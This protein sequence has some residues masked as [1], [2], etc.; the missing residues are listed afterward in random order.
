MC[1]ASGAAS[2]AVH[3]TKIMKQHMMLMLWLGLVLGVVDGA[4]VIRLTSD[5]FETTTQAA[6]GQTTGIWS[7]WGEREFFPDETAPLITTPPS[8]N[9]L[10]HFRGPQCPPCD[11]I[12]TIMARYDPGDFPGVAIRMAE[13]DVDQSKALLTRFAMLQAP[14][15]VLFRSR[16][17]YVYP[18]NP[19]D[20]PDRA[21][22]TMV[23]F[24]QQTYASVAELQVPGMGLL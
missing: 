5:D 11:A 17:M 15:L 7:A 2:V 19:L 16:H 9:R 21:L 6:T 1:P 14:A 23:A 20:A 24:A 22:E 3:H 8:T 18:H 4:G 10:V 12:T 13:V